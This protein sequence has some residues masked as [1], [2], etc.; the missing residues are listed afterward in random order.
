MQG[1]RLTDEEI[2]GATAAIRVGFCV[3][4]LLLIV[5]ISDQDSKVYKQPTMMGFQAS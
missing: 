5:L 1:F 2:E 4:G 3:Q